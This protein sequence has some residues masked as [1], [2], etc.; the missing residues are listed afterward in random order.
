MSCATV[1]AF[2]FISAHGTHHGFILL[3][4]SA[5]RSKMQKKKATNKVCSGFEVLIVM[6]C[7]HGYLWKIR[8]SK[9]IASTFPRRRAPSISFSF[10]HQ[11]FHCS[12]E[13][14]LRAMKWSPAKSGKSKFPGCL[15]GCVPVPKHLLLCAQNTPEDRG[16]FVPP[17]SYLQVQQ[18]V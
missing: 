2:M 13:S 6:S 11:V 18:V 9:T 10:N 15:R 17:E 4:W 12:A 8:V 14:S 1:R 3:L 5:K 16:R 7:P